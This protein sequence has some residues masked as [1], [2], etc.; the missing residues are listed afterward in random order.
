MDKLQLEM[1]RYFKCKFVTPK[2]FLGLDLSISQPGHIQLAMHT[3]TGKKIDALQI[4]DGYPGE[5]LTPS[6][7]DKKSVRGEGIEPNDTFRSK[8]GSL[9]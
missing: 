4:R 9:N 6:R 5:I 3:F 7:T 8:V 1:K 2:D